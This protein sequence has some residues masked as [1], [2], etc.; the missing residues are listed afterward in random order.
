MTL[1]SSKTM[2]KQVKLAVLTVTAT[3]SPPGMSARSQGQSDVSCLHSG[4]LHN[5]GGAGDSVLWGCRLG[6]SLPG[7]LPV[8]VGQQPHCIF[9]VVWCLVQL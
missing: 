9:C 6:T 3:R 5:E 8:A 4:E 2:R 1:S 7:L